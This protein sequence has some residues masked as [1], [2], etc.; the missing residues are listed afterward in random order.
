MFDKFWKLF[1]TA[2]TKIVDAM[3]ISIQT[4]IFGCIGIIVIYILVTTIISKQQDQNQ[5]RKQR[6]EKI[7]LKKQKEQEI[8]EIESSNFY[9]EL[10]MLFRKNN[11]T[12][13]NINSVKI[14]L[15]SITCERFSLTNS[16]DFEIF[17]W[18]LNNLGFKSVDPK[19]LEIFGRIL[20]SDYDITTQRYDISNKHMIQHNKRMTAD[21]HEEHRLARFEVDLK[22]SI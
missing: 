1:D 18:K 14:T 9:A 4:L 19:R 7:K 22:P 12:A 21:L 16:K 2:I 3:G 20:F 17:E 5:V 11:I 10:K 13:E 6:Q 15:G 8:T